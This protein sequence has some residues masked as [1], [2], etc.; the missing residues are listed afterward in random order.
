MN[1]GYFIT[2]TDTDVGKTWCTLGVM[3]RLQQLG[4]TVVGMK[5]VASGCA[6]TTEGYRNADALRI[7][8]QG[9]VPV[10]Y[11]LINPY[12][13]APAVAPHIAA[14]HS[15]RKIALQQILD[16]YEQLRWQAEQVVV[17]GVGGWLVPLNGEETVA[18]LARALE[19]PVI[20]VVGLRLGC[21]N[22]ALLTAESIRRHGCEL[23]GWIA[24][25]VTPQMAELEQ[26]IQAIASR[27]DTPLLG[28]VAHQ[29]SL[30]AGCIA[31]ALSLEA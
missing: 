29:A 24:N 9:S 11:P 16:S 26:N 17:E 1:K 5:P 31:A 19:L 27:I 25:T 23:A 22:H 6:V 14:A 28:I 4:A 3:A 13:F 20:L 8:A 12:A 30:D 21:I 10:D 15:G 7:Q 2:G 18:D